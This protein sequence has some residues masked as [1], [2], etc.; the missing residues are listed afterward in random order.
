MQDSWV[1]S[2]HGSALVAVASVLST[3]T[4]LPGPNTKAEKKGVYS[5]ESFTSSFFYTWWISLIPRCGLW[6]VMFEL[7]TDPDTIKRPGDKQ[8]VSTDPARV[9]VTT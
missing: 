9:L 3:K 7:R 4:L 1:R 6:R 8:L 5:F 2:F